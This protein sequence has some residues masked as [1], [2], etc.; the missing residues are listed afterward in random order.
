MEMLLVV[1]VEE[2]V[3]EELHWVLEVGRG[4]HIPVL[5]CT[6]NFGLEYRILENQTNRLNLLLSTKL[7]LL[8]NKSN[9]CLR[10]EETPDG[11]G[12]GH[13]ISGRSRQP[14]EDLT[15][16]FGVTENELNDLLASMRQER[17]TVVLVRIT[18]TEELRERERER[19][20]FENSYI[21]ENPRTPKPLTF[22]KN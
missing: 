2:R 6:S 4:F 15:K 8:C 11:N 16:R 21:P 9:A 22:S 17:A 10:C 3:K 13:H 12:E 1:W 7:N 14:K 19:R 5:E 18:N 20:S